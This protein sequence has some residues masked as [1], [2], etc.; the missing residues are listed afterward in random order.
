VQ[1]QHKQYSLPKDVPVTINTLEEVLFKDMINDISFEI[2]GKIVVLIEHQSTIN[3]NMALRMLMYVGRVYEKTVMDDGIYTTKKITIPAPEFF[4]FYNGEAP[5]PDEM[6][7]KLSDAFEKLPA[8]LVPALSERQ[9][10]IQRDV[11]LE[12]I[13]RVIN[14]N[15]G[16]N[17]DLARKCKAL[18]HYSVFVG[19][20]REYTKAG[21]GLDEAARKAV[22]YCL[23]HGILKEFLEKNATEVLGMLMTE[24]NWDDALAVHYREGREGG[25]EEGIEMGIEKTARNAL[26]KGLSIDVIHDI[27]GLDTE[28]I[29]NLQYQEMR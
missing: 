14:I 6:I 5:Y 29:K 26:M 19:R 28:T 15:E 4:V 20:M 2:G 12:L 21:M 13:V 7:L 24:W 8:W 16:R 9:G 1:V 23:K 11:N 25:I 18:A 27:T 17:A 10:S 22:E 3:P